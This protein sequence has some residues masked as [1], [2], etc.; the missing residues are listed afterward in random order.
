MDWKGG[1]KFTGTSR[2]GHSITCDGS[3]KV[4][5]EEDG[6][7]PLELVVFALA[8]C[9]GM[10]VISITNKMRQDI[11]DLKVDAE[12]EQRED[13]PRFLTKAHITYHITGTNLDRAKIERAVEL[14]EERYCVVG[15]TISGITKITHTINIT[16]K[17]QE[18]AKNADRV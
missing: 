4:G 2:Y 6:Y 1:L 12:V 14:S 13:H 9:T 8:S 18:R 15:A 7:Q 3:K 16:E 10:D 17:K 11:T 5:G